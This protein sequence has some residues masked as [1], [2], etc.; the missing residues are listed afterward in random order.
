MMKPVST[1][2][3]S[4]ANGGTP[5]KSRVSHNASRLLLPGDTK[6]L[7][8]YGSFHDLP[9]ASWN[10]LGAVAALLVSAAL[11]LV[12]HGGLACFLR[13]RSFASHP[14]RN[15]R[16]ARHQRSCHCRAA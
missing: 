14:D 10:K 9:T 7:R 11:V 8:A 16:G 12:L 15:R 13:E 3:R 6:A 1:R 4:S 5:A 2:H